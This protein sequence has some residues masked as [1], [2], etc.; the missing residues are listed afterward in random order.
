MRFGSKVEL[1]AWL[2]IVATSLYLTVHVI[3]A[4]VR[5]PVLP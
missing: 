5:G 4:A 1:Y 3:V 2:L